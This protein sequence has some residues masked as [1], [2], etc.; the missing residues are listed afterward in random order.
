MQYLS[1]DILSYYLAHLEQL[2]PDKQFHLASRLYLWDQTP[3]A[4]DLI[5]DL[6]PYFSADDNP[7]HAVEDVIAY[8]LSSPIHGSKNAAELRR[9]HFERYPKLKAYVSALFRITFLRHIYDYDVR[10]VF[11]DHFPANETRLLID[12]LLGDSQALAILSTHAVNFLYLYSRVLVEDD[13]LFDPALFLEIGATEY[14][15]SN[16]LHLQLLIY[17]YTHC[18]IGESQF[19]YRALPNNPVYIRMMEELEVII[20]EHFADINLDNKF[21]FLTCARITGFSSSLE[22]KIYAE[23]EQSRSPNGTFLIDTHNNNPQTAN[24]DLATSEH[25]NVLFILAN[26]QFSP[27]A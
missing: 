4:Q 19:Y 26:K 10:S 22:S 27:L 13:T 24:S 17:L 25:R 6:R 21:E 20:G 23:A 2:P 8:A 9:P 12:E 18:I 1:N 15:R 16:P 14:D 3:A 5:T 11:T 7:K